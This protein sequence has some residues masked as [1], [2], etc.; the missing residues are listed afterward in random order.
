LE[1]EEILRMLLENDAPYNLSKK[2]AWQQSII[3]LA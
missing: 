3:I 1:K 2:P